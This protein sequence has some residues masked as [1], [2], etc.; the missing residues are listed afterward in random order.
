MRI[1]ISIYISCI[2]LTSYQFALAQSVGIG[3]TTPSPKAALEIQAAGSQGMILPR[4]NAND[5]ISLSPL[6]A[7]E[8]GL[9]FYDTLDNVIRLWNG[10]AWDTYSPQS[11]PSPPNTWSMAGNNIP[12]GAFIGSTNDQSFD[13]RTDNTNR[14]F[15]SNN[16]NIGIGTTTPEYEVDFQTNDNVKLQLSARYNIASEPYNLN[17]SSDRARFIVAFEDGAFRQALVLGDLDG[18]GSSN[19]IFGISQSSNSGS[20]WDPSLTISGNGNVGINKN[21][22]TSTLDVNGTFAL[23]EGTVSSPINSPLETGNNSF[24]SFVGVS[25]TIIISGIDNPSPGK[26]IILNNTTNQ[27]VILRSNSNTVPASLRIS[28]GNNDLV[29]N[30]RGTATLIYSEAVSR[31]ILLSFRM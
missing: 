8:K 28:T 19:T 10:A 30:G 12:S 7:R 22:A 4:L 9:T 27:D 13:I 23:S 21:A 17:T 3:T 15:F 1:N 29:I 24:I 14:M 26:I 5:T 11:S 31:W 25:S 18:G 6:G 2:L 20:T 16:G